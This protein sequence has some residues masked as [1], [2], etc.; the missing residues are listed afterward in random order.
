MGNI[1]KLFN[2][3]ATPPE[4][5]DRAIRGFRQRY[6]HSRQ[7]LTVLITAVRFHRRRGDYLPELHYGLDVLQLDPNNLYTLSTL[8]MAIPENVRSTD[9]DL[10]QRLAQA[11]S[12]D[13]K[14]LAVAHSFQ[15]TPQGLSYGGNHFTAAQARALTDNL[16]GPAYASLGRIAWIRKQYAPAI[17]AYR[18]ALA[19]ETTATAKSQTWYNIAIS[20]Q[21]QGHTPQAQAALKTAL[22]LAPPGSL[23]NAMVMRE[24]QR[25]N[26]AASSGVPR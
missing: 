10:E 13:R 1:A 21:A 14:V 6:P 7:M 15:I 22:G 18:Q 19:Y 5:F 8:G 16:A 23:L 25:V 12:Y 4:V 20:E 11:E 24:L 2:D 17:A 3:P 9:L 26:A